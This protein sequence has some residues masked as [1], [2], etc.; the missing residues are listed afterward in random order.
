[1]VEVV[2]HEANKTLEIQPIAQGAA[3]IK[4]KDLCITSRK[5]AEVSVDVNGVG[6]IKVDVVDEIQ[7]GDETIMQ[8]SVYDYASNILSPEMLGLIRLQLQSPKSDI[9]QIQ[10]FGKLPTDSYLRYRVKGKSLGE[11]TISFY[12]DGQSEVMGLG[13]IKSVPKTISVFPPLKLSPSN[14]VMLVGS[15]YQI[16]SFGGPQTNSQIQFSLG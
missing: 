15:V 12:A 2:Y 3:K 7:L 13:S 1:M 11:S 16:T 8:V 9:L 14:L 5:E 10:Q 6:Y 4:V